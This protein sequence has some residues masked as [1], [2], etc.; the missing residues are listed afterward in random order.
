M[1]SR[2]GYTLAVLTV[3]CAFVALV[4]GARV[5]SVTAMPALDPA[6]VGLWKNVHRGVSTFA[7]LGA[8]ALALRV[9]GAMRWWLLGTLA[10]AGLPGGMLEGKAMAKAAGLVHAV[11]AS[12]MMSVCAAAALR[13]RAGWQDA[14]AGVVD[15][16]SPSLE[17]LAKA[18]WVAL[19]LQTA[20]GAL[21]R[22]QIVGLMAHVSG[23]LVVMGM[24]MYAGI[25]AFSTEG[26]PK[27]VK[28]PALI[29]LIMTGVQMLIGLGAYLYRMQVVEQATGH[30][31]ML[32][33][34]VIHVAVGAMTT[35]VC[36]LMGMQISRHVRPAVTA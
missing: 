12:A 13:L 24:V 34:T 18:T 36:A 23:A 31:A 33:F 30:M 3:V 21:Y 29:L 25:A 32:T 9:G 2:T 5:T 7:G 6:G 35:A 10:L 20:L 17:T 14:V 11:G 19:L 22:H 15:E 8:L 1:N 16:G 4:T 27:A 28:Q 26:A